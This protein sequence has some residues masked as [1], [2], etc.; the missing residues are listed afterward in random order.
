MKSLI[1]LI[2]I[3]LVFIFFVGIAMII[4]GYQVRDSELKDNFSSSV[5]STV[6]NLMAKKAYAITDKNQFISDFMEDISYSLKTNSKIQVNIMKED[7][8]KGMMSI[9]V[10]EIFTNPNGKES[11]VSCTRTVLFNKVQTTEKGNYTVTFYDMKNGDI[12]KQISVLEGEKITPPKDPI[13]Q[14]KTFAGWD[15][16]NGYAADF[17]QPVTQELTYY[18]TWK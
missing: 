13:Q 9:R 3:S 11:K 16:S 1:R 5:E 17:S 14:G 7:K 15:D 18:A 12:Y 8:E 6:S 4:G 2:G 10:K